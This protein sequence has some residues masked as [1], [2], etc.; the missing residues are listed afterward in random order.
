MTED[1]IRQLRIRV[2]HYLTPEVA[3]FAGMT[4][5]DLQ[6]FISGQ[7][8]PSKDQLHRLALRMGVP[9]K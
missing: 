4:L 8:Q 9:D 2:H 7:Y 1:T 3:S 6:Q 5:A